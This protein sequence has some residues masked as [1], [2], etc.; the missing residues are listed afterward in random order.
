MA[1]KLKLPFGLNP[2]GDLVEISEVERGLACECTCPGCGSRLKA[3]KGNEKI[4]H[5]AHHD[6]TKC[7]SG[8][9]TV[10]HLAAKRVIEEEGKISLPEFGRE[11]SNGTWEPLVDKRVLIAEKVVLEKKVNQIIPDVV[12]KNNKERVLVEIAVTHFADEKKQE[13][14]ENLGIS[15][16]EVNLSKLYKKG[17]I[18]LASLKEAVVESTKYKK[19]LYSVEGNNVLREKARKEKE[20]EERYRQEMEKARLAEEWRKT[21]ADDSYVMHCPKEKRKGKGGFFA[22]VKADCESCK[23]FEG[24][25]KDKGQVLCGKYKRIGMAREIA[26]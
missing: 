18:N 15:A 2:N 14:I 8:L 7:T 26:Q 23:R 10:L 25:D 5:F 20:E 9:E 22:K 13:K 24:I 1:K 3:R 4:H 16:I 19:W 21:L 6:D 11:W 17:E 12:V